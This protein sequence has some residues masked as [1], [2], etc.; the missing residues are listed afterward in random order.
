MTK[1][2]SKST[3]AQPKDAGKK[4]KVKKLALQDLR[5]VKGGAASARK[6]TQMEQR[7]KQQVG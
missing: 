7:P 3:D 1:K 5:S 4:R 6:K 2:R